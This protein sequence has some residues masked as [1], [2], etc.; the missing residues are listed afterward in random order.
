M[1]FFDRSRSTQIMSLV[2]KYLLLLCGGQSPS[3]PQIGTVRAE[4]TLQVHW[5]GAQVQ[6]LQVQ[7]ALPQPPMMSYWFEYWLLV[8]G[9]DAFAEDLKFA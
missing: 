7:P 2:E 8:V 4:H 5:P 9:I 1:K 3:S 6:E